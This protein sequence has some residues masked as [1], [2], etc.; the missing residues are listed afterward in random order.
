MLDLTLQDPNI[1]DF[2]FRGMTAHQEHREHVVSLVRV[3]KTEN[4]ELGD[5]RGHQDVQVVT[6][7]VTIVTII[8]TIIV[9]I[10]VTIA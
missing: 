5:I 6:I 9:M 3:G 1:S 4:L 2:L 10:L 8:V 7:I